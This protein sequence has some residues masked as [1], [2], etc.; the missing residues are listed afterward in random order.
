[1]LLLAVG[2]ATGKKEDKELGVLRVHI[3]SNANVPGVAQDV[4]VLR[5]QPLLVTVRMEP[6][7]T[8]ANVIAA[9]LLETPGGFAVEV[10]FDESG[11]LTLE[12]YTSTYAGKHFVLFGQWGD[13]VKDGRWLATPVISHRIANGVLSF[14]PDASLEETRKLVDSLN[15]TAKRNAK[16]R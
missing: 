2:C 9:H 6:V 15:R 7:L 12:Q 4:S 14:S 3:E 8:E 10:K 1:M 16:D 5:S 11:S 13:K